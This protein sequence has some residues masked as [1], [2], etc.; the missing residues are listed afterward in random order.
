MAIPVA[1]VHLA[2]AHAALPG[3]LPTPP[4]CMMLPL[5]RTPPCAAAVV[6]PSSAPKPSRADA[7]G[8]WDAHK[9]K[10][11]KQ[12]GSPAS[13][14]SSFSDALDGKNHLTTRTSSASSSNSRAYS[15]ERWDAHKKPPAASPGASSS[16]S[17]RRSSSSSSKTKTCRQISKRLPNN[18]R[19]STSS[20]AERWD[21]HK[22]KKP[23][24]AELDDGESSSTGSND[25]ELLDMLMPQQPTPRSLYY[26]GPGFIAVPEPSMLPLP[27][28]L[29]SVA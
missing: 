27:S 26:A 4:K 17:A 16:S 5:L 7:A 8:R 13:T 21:A 2:M 12:T 18:G 22:N 11:N 9:N 28:F 3:L 10:I 23:P 20:A 14:S 1:R 29:I 6:L 15:D 19:A 24:V 25:V